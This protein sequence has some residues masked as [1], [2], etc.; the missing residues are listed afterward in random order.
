MFL[1]MNVGFGVRQTAGNVRVDLLLYALA[2]VVSL[3]FPITAAI[4]NYL[5][6]DRRKL[7]DFNLKNAMIFRCSLT[8]ILLVLTY[9]INIC[10]GMKTTSAEGYVPS[11]VIP[12]VMSFNFI[13]STL[14]FN[15]LYTSKKF[16]AED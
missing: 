3:A 15:L 11:L 6:P 8:I 1:A 2:V 5:H 4:L 14:I 13:F 10:C 12:M 16:A 7:C 9:L